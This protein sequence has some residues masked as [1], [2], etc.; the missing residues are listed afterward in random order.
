LDALAG[1]VPSCEGLLLLCL[2][3]HILVMP[4]RA[5]VR[6]G[7]GG[8]VDV[9]P[10]GSPLKVLATQIEVP[11]IESEVVVRNAQTATRKSSRRSIRV[12]RLVGAILSR[13]IEPHDLRP[14]SRLHNADGVPPTRRP[15][16][17][18]TILVSRRVHPGPELSE[19]APVIEQDL[20][21][22]SHERADVRD[23]RVLLSGSG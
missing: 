8:D 12:H 2:G 13:R 10:A 18:A 21:H 11:E 17:S 15:A 5:V 9:Q 19:R 4:R 6:A 16:S 20:P 1:D 22:V 3:L 7:V 23:L 14:S